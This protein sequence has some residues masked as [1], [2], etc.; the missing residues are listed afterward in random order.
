MLAQGGLV[1]GPA[2]AAFVGFTAVRA[3]PRPAPPARPATGCCSPPS[4]RLD[5]LPGA[6]PGLHRPGAA[7]RPA[8]HPRRR[9]C[10]L[11][12]SRPGCARSPAGRAPARRR[13]PERPEGPPAAGSRRRPGVGSGR[14]RPGALGV[15]GAG[16]ACRLVRTS[17]RCGPT[18]PSTNG[19]GRLR[20]GDGT[21][22]LDDYRQGD[23]AGARP[24][25]LAHQD[26]H[27]AGG[28]RRR[29]NLLRRW[30]TISRLAVDSYEVN[31][32]R[33]AASLAE[34]DGH[35]DAQ[36]RDVRAG[37][38]AGPAGTT[39][40]WCRGHVRAA[41]RRGRAAR[42]RRSPR[43]G[44]RKRRGRVI[45][46]SAGPSA[47]GALGD[48]RAVLGDPAAARAAYE[49]ALAVQ[50]DQPPPW[51]GSASWPPPESRRRVSRT[52]SRLRRDLP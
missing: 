30:A 22:A 40:S 20:T 6:V 19:D 41:A 25:L 33:A 8:L 49:R 42:T 7:A 9:R 13:A 24:L 17:S 12:R 50:P 39:S 4:G 5:R 18:S 43:L 2:Y 27:A 36:P 35:L 45:T 37:G 29:R 16:P 46:A 32:L 10:S 11:P 52:T 34:P 51:P 28:G 1:L 47:L 48:A 14:R 44:C 38:R 23:R 21:A 26:R 3:R 31:A 15:V